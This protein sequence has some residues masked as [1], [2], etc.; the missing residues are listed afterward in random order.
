[1]GERLQPGAPPRRGPAYA[2]RDRA[3]PPVVAGQQGDDAVGLA[4]LVGAQHDRLVAIER[5]PPILPGD[6]VSR[7]YADGG[8]APSSTRARSRSPPR[9]SRSGVARH[10]RMLR[11]RTKVALGISSASIAASAAGWIGSR[12]W[13]TTRAGAVIARRSPRRRRHP[14]EEHPVHDGRHRVRP[15][16]AGVEGDPDPERHHAARH[17]P[18][19]HA[20]RPLTVNGR[21]RAANISGAN[22]RI[23]AS[24][25]LLSTGIS[26]ISPRTRSGA[27]TATSRETLAPSDVPP[28][29]A[30]ARTEVVQQRHD[31]LGER[32]HGVRVRVGGPVG[33]AVAE[34]VEGDDVQPLGGQ[35]AGQRLVHPARH[36]LAVEQHHPGVAAAVLGVL[37]P[38]PGAV[39]LE[40]ELTDPLRDQHGGNVTGPPRR[41]RIADDPSPFRADRDATGPVGNGHKRGLFT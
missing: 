40:E 5:H 10:S 19:E 37:E 20:A 2:L 15:L 41:G 11:A 35:R 22:A 33:A 13:P 30:C 29:T 14:A 17:R 34:Q 4:Q 7:W 38:V 9:L 23:P 28:T 31:L 1:M 16:V 32:R 25:A 18:G 12:G 27:S 6:R 39:L 3:H 24:T 21:N 36:Q 8:A 26:M